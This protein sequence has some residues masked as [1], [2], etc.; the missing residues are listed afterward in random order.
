MGS[1]FVFGASFFSPSAAAS[2]A[3]SSAGAASAAASAAALSAPSAS[4]AAG[5][6]A[7]SAAA[8]ASAA[9]GADNLAAVFQDQAFVQ[10]ILSSLPGVDPNDPAIQSVLKNLEKKD[11]GGEKK[12]DKK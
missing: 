2:S 9:G 5:A 3:A 6:S 11:E 7:A 1:C 4:A 8:G 10:G 12:D